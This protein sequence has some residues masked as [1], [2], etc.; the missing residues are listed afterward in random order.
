LQ[1]LAVKEFVGIFVVAATKQRAYTEAI[2]VGPEVYKAMGKLPSLP[3]LPVAEL[4]SP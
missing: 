2:S 3:Y 4:A 1:L